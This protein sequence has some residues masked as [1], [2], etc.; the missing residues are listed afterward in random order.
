LS[1]Q[2]ANLTE[3]KANRQSDNFILT[4]TLTEPCYYIV[5]TCYTAVAIEFTNKQSHV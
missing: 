5:N 2:F 3:D 1:E 4:L